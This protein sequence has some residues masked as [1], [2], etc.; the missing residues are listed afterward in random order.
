MLRVLVPRRIGHG[1]GTV[2]GREKPVGDIDRDLLLALVLEPIQQQ[3][4]IEIASSSARPTPLPAQCRQL[5]VGDQGTVVE[6]APD[7]GRLAVI[8][9]SAGQEMQQILGSR[10]YELATVSGHQK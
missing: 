8:N 4:K 6:Q 2:L 3:A 10:R 1:E 9:R 5:V 7:Q